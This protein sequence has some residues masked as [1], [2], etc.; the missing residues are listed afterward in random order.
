MNCN[1]IR[2]QYNA[3]TIRQQDTPLRQIHIKTTTHYNNNST[4]QKQSNNSTIR[5][6]TL[7]CKSDINKIRE[8]YTVATNKQHGTS[9]HTMQHQLD[10]SSLHQQSDK[11]AIRPRYTATI[12]QKHCNNKTLQQHNTISQ[13]N[14]TTAIRQH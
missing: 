2:K 6:S 13:K 4:L 5:Q 12:R 9:V 3:T 8:Q 1:T 10:N 14:T 11:V 7:Q